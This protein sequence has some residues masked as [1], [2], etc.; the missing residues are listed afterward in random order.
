MLIIIMIIIIVVLILILHLHSHETSRGDDKHTARLL[1][2]LTT[3]TSSAY[4]FKS[5]AKLI[6]LRVCKTEETTDTKRHTTLWTTLLAQSKYMPV[7]QQQMHNNQEAANHQEKVY[8]HPCP[9]RSTNS[10]IDRAT[11]KYKEYVRQ[12]RSSS[13]ANGHKSVAMSGCCRHANTTA[14]S[15]SPSSS[16]SAFHPP[17][18]FVHSSGHL[19][20]RVD[21]P[22]NR[23]TIRKKT[24]APKGRKEQHIHHLLMHPHWWVN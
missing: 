8:I 12:M 20:A 19:S 14:T 4:T 24:D 17:S 23:S 16:S 6:P 2:T 13:L 21:F 5:H 15:S 7:W 3:A 22:F 9:T 18:I 10:Q 11:Q 1:S